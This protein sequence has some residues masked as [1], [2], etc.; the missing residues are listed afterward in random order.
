VPY[1]L[2][3]S[4]AFR[5]IGVSATLLLIAAAI[6]LGIPQATARPAFGPAEAFSFTDILAEARARAATPYRE[7]ENPLR[8]ALARLDYDRHQQI[9]FESEYTLWGDDPSSV[10]IELFH[11][12]RHFEDPVRI[13]LVENG[14]ARE[15]LFDPEFFSYGADAAFVRDLEPVP[16]FAG[17][18]VLSPDG[19]E[20]LAFLGASY[21]RSPGE[22]GQY[23]ISAR[24]VA[25]A[26]GQPEP[27]EFPRFK[28]FWLERPP[29]GGDGIVIHALLDG[30][31]ITG[32]FRFTAA[33][34]G[35]VVMDVDAH[36]FAR[37]EIAQLGIA[38]LT[39]MYWYSK[40]TTQGAEDWRPQVHDSEGLAILDGDGRQ[41]WRPLG[42][43]PTLSTSR[44][45][46]QNPRG[47]GLLQRD[48]DFR[49]YEDALA[50]YERRPSLWV[51]PLGAWGRGAVELVEIPTGNEFLD[52][53]VAY[54]RPE[55]A[56]A[57]GRSLA[58]GYRL[59]WLAEPAEVPVIGRVVATRMMRS[60]AH[61]HPPRPGEAR[62]VID[63]DGPPL[64][65]LRA[66]AP[67]R[68]VATTSRGK[69]DA[70][71]VRIPQ[72]GHWRAFLE[73]QFDGAAPVELQLHLRSG[74]RA[75]TESWTYLHHELPK[76][77][78]EDV[79]ATGTAPDG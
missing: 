32:A 65:E 51:E 6:L 78:L 54:W 44:F 67:V 15:V 24:G 13:F 26:T 23:G 49:N 4:L 41:L 8:D 39:S 37:R 76:L 45:A 52:N 38:P 56:M 35:A 16:G 36:L 46:G 21:F 62:F 47:F 58:L 28:S 19:L 60:L 59:H 27:E 10:G 61:G 77:I 69:L 29:G 25:L 74:A 9:R 63:F 7:V 70:E 40:R 71:V 64:T 30:P 34:A 2:I 3:S 73:I 31:S 14:R 5:A 53:I 75:L 79:A 50:R 66:D 1:V 18:R 11:P 68:V 42:N 22:L 72:T 48:R 43:P 17:F 12:G 57:A 55:S 33:K 20:W